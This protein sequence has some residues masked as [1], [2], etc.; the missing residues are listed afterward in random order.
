M[1]ARAVAESQEALRQAL[2]QHPQIDTLW[3]GFSGGLDSTALLWLV[4]QTAPELRPGLKLRALHVN[5]NL[6]PEA[7][8][9][10][11][12]CRSVCAH[13]DI[14]FT[15]ISVKPATASEESARDARYHAFEQE[16]GGR[17]LLLLAHHRDDQAETFM[18]RLF[19]GSGVHGLAAMEQSRVLGRG[20]LLRPLLNLSREELEAVVA[21]S[22]LDWIEDPS[23]QNS[24]YLRNWV[25]NRLSEM[26]AQRWPDWRAKLASTAAWC[27]EASQLNAD[28]AQIDAGGRF[29]N[30]Q[31]ITET[32]SSSKR[33]LNNLLF[34]WL[35]AQG[36]RPGSRS[37]L[38]EV[39]VQIIDRKSGSWYFGQQSLHLY[40][41]QL[42]LEKDACLPLQA[43]ALVLQAGEAKLSSGILEIQ[44][45]EYGLAPGLQVLVR[46][47]KEGDLVS[48]KVGKQSLKKFMNAQKVPPWLRDSW[49]VIELE[50]QIISVV[51]LWCAES[52]QTKGG[53]ALNWRR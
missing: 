14:E 30:P 38:E 41:Q 24:D 10:V 51:G 37:Q 7:A 27:D 32:L 31:P 16:I 18:M 15:A 25:R 43:Q 29:T 53:L 21:V 50:G 35:R 11:E 49:P 36:V 44:S 3:V 34:Y 45:S 28:L 2:L 40:Q 39:A 52:W 20:R 17:D 8:S 1:I 46:G 22:G 23:N 6:L 13:L 33:R 9:W 19:R 4:H 12:H 47:R 48:L 42:W 5:H 26:L